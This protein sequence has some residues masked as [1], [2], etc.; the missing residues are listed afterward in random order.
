M[1]ADRP[2][3]LTAGPRRTDDVRVPASVQAAELAQ[4]RIRMIALENLVIALLAEQSD[5]QRD[6][7][8]NMASYIS[9]RPGFT[10]HRATLH[11][12]AQMVHLVERAARFRRNAAPERA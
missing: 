2:M 5:G 4:L 9:P 10:R 1:N 11:A 7:A 6:L 8:R 3:R 12:A